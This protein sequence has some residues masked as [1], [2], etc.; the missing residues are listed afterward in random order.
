MSFVGEV[1]PG[2]FLVDID[3]FGEPGLG[4]AYIFVVDKEIAMVD[5]GTSRSK[6]RILRALADLGLSCERVRW[7]FLTHVH[8]DHAGGAGVLLPEFP[9]AT[10]VVHPRG[11]KHLVDP[12]KLVAS[13]Q[14]VTGARFRF[15]GEAKPVPEDRVHAA[16]DGESFALG[17]LR[18]QAV[19]SPGHA[20]HH[21][22]FFVPKEGLLFTGDAAGLYLKGNLLPTTVPPNFDLEAWLGTLAK[23]QAL[24]PKRLL[25][26]HFGPGGPELLGEYGKLLLAWVE[27]VRPYKDM[28]EEEAVAAVLAGVAAEGWPMGPGVSG[29]WSMSVRGVLQYLRR[30]EARG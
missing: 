26:T 6:D 14:S 10:V 23:L 4:G 22:C 11:A 17:S 25:F 18:I 13:T 20:P 7:I 27:K 16:Q 12:S 1:L 30:K 29:D 21:L 8:L 15:Y 2:L 3:H 5:S 19:D 28:P 24:A 9:N